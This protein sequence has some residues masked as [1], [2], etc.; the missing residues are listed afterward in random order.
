MGQVIR[1]TNNWMVHT[2]LDKLTSVV[3]LMVFHF[4]PHPHMESH[5]SHVPNHQPVIINHY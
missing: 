3:P 5:K 4:D 2:K 1:Y